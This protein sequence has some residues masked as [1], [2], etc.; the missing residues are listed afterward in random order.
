MPE[1]NGFAAFESSFAD[2]IHHPRRG[3][4]RVNGIEQKAFEADLAQ[5]LGPEEA[6]R[7][8]WAPELCAERRQ[9]RASE[10]REDR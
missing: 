4:S 9:F 8:A 5:R 6:K 7:L 10:D 3:A 2:Q 1:Q